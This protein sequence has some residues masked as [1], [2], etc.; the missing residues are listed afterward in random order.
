MFNFFTTHTHKNKELAVIYDIGSSSVGG[1]LVYLNRDSTPDIVYTT[2]KSVPFK[3]EVDPDHLLNAVKGAINEVGEEIQ[4]KGMR[5]LQFTKLGDATIEGIYCVFAS[6]W[7]ISQTQTLS[8]SSDNEKEI[9]Q[10]YLDSLIDSSEDTLKEGALSRY[11]DSVRD[12]LTELEERIIQVKLN[13][14]ITPNPHGKKANSIEMSVFTSMIPEDVLDSVESS[15]SK[16]FNT[17]HYHYHSFTLASF[18]TFRNILADLN[19]S[20][21]LFMDITGE[22]TDISIIKDECI[23][24]SLSFPL[25]KHELIRAIT[26]AL[27]TDAGEGM[28]RLR[29]WAEGSLTDEE[30]RQVEEIISDIG[31]EWKEA[32][33]DAVSELME[34]ATLPHRLFFLADEDVGPIFHQLIEEVRDEKT[35]LHPE[36]TKIVFVDGEMFE[37]YSDIQRGAENDPFLTL[38]TIFANSLPVEE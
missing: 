31:G 36:Y 12:E 35:K 29:M 22:L 24:K 30:A 23:K 11:A 14:Y 33:T 2:R 32:F 5:H 19:F 7:Y 4:K 9:T 25:G 10:E 34:E 13:G 28:S 16:T 3:Q 8:D 27:D 18:S 21:F 6:P 20:D 37:D 1:A 17:K 15:I 38:A 26:T